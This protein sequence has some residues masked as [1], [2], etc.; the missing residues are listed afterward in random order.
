VNVRDKIVNRMKELV[1][2]TFNSVAERLSLCTLN[3]YPRQ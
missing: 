2:I 1:K 3:K